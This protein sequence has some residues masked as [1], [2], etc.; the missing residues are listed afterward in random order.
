MKSAIRFTVFVFATIALAALG[1]HGQVPPTSHSLT[2]TVTNAPCPAG[3]P[4]ATCG[5]V[6]SIAPVT[7]SSCPSTSGTTY[8]PQNQSAPVPQPTSGNATYTDSAHSGQTVCAIGQT[9]QG[10]AY[11][12][13]SSAIGPFTIP[14]APTPPAVSA[15]EAKNDAKP[16]PQLQPTEP[17]TA[18]LD[19]K[20]VVR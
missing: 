7:G 16:L 3:T 9:A 19:L 6:F 20:A 11:S 10:T 13:P 15:T 4:A 18:K 1:C 14:A 12:Q 5:Y 17:Q 2:I 8:S